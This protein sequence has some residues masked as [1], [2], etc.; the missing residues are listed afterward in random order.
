MKPVVALGLA[1]SVFVA[2]S[3]EA[4]DHWLQPDVLLSPD[5]AE[6]RVSQIVGEGFVKHD[7]LGHDP[8]KALRFALAGGG[9]ATVQS[10]KIPARPFVGLSTDDVADIVHL[11]ETRLAAAAA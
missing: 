1:L 11:I 3:A 9:F 2:R 10:V 4:H 6:V 8:S 5:G 7:E